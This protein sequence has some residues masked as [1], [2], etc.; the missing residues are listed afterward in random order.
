MME[1]LTHWV[2]EDPSA[3]GRPRLPGDDP[4][5]SMAVPMMLLC[6]VQQLSEGREQEAPQRY[7][8]LEGWCVEQV[9]QHIQ[10]GAQSREKYCLFR[11]FRHLD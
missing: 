3:L 9:L 5:N 11:L 7:R 2:R 10:V 6:L 8:E 1:Q 4:V